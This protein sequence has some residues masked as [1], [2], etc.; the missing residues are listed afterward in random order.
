MGSLAIT[1]DN[2]GLQGSGIFA[3]FGVPGAFVNNIVV[4]RPTQSSAPSVNAGDN[5]APGLPARD[6][7]GRP[8]IIDGNVDQGIY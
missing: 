4:S 2:D 6:F 3:D 7:D 5:L 8:R 1:L